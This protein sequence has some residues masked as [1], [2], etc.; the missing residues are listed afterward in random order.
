M[1]KD[2]LRLSLAPCDV[3]PWLMTAFMIPRMPRLMPGSCTRARERR[4][5]IVI[6]KRTSSMTTVS[7]TIEVFPLFILAFFVVP[8]KP[9]KLIEINVLFTWATVNK[10]DSMKIIWCS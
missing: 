4:P 3:I 1:Q 2:D 8:D 7:F 9:D 6:P 5:S 10:S